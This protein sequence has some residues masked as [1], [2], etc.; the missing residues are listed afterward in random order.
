MGSITSAGT[1]SG[2]PID[3]IIQSLVN[4][5]QQPQTQLLDIRQATLQT[6]LSAV[7]NLKSALSTFQDSVSKLTTLSD[8]Q[9][10]TA[11]ST[12]TKKATATA[13]TGAIAGTYSITVDNL[14]SGSRLESSGSFTDSSAL[15]AS[16]LAATANLTFTAGTASF[17][18]SVDSTTTLAQLRDAV[19][20]AGSSAGVTATI[21]NTGSGSKL[22]FNSSKTGNGNTLSVSNDD[23]LLNGV[24]SVVTD[25]DPGTAGVQGTAGL[26]VAQSSQDAQVSLNGITITSATN[27]FADIVDGVTLTAV[28]K[29]D[30]GSPISITVGRDTKTLSSAIK[31][32]VDG[33][34]T[35]Y[36][37]LK[38]LGQSSA[39][40]DGS[41]SAGPLA[42]DSQ[43]RQIEARIRSVLSTTVSGVGKY[44]NLAQLGITTNRDGTLSLDSTKLDAAVS[45]DADG[46]AQLFAGTKGIA[47]TL[48][49]T[50][51]Q[52]VDSTGTLSSREQSIQGQLRDVDKS[53]EDLSY[54]I[55]QLKDRL[56][57]Q[58]SALDSLVAGLNSTGSY[59]T[60]QLSKL[61]SSSSG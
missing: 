39:N 17:S 26:T 47:K 51:G 37:T 56:T 10:F 35:A 48:D 12:D 54:R 57:R 38:A 44:S 9:K 7:G 11:T 4:A 60:Q 8:F 50:L 24:S 49:D 34:N 14:A 40:A 6:T 20:S 53:R 5:E 27:T 58:Y 59:L 46:V 52:Y 33:F 2:L 3:T 22:V 55:S 15:V 32:L 13:T 29:T 30:A 45:N 18:V 61:S 43:L 19:N 1:G 31:S 16:G 28:A 36:K 41:V 21:V 25:E 42:G 23:A